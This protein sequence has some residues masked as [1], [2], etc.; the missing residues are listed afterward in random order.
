MDNPVIIIIYSVVEV[1]A[2]FSSSATVGDGA[3]YI[4]FR[5]S[6]STTFYGDLPIAGIQI[7]KSNGTTIENPYP[8][9]GTC[10]CCWNSNLDI[11]GTRMA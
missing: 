11:T 4:G 3:L 10:G 5:N 7:L 6:A 2:E 1:Q 9:F 8:D